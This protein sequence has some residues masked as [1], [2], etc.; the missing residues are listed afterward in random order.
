[1]II[2]YCSVPCESPKKISPQ[3]LVIEKAALQKAAPADLQ[4]PSLEE[5]LPPSFDHRKSRMGLGI[6][7]KEMVRYLPDCSIADGAPHKTL[8]MCSDC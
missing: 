6:A 3:V 2:E 1:M 4:R 5:S 7:R 8:K